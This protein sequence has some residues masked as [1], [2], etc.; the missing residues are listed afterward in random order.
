MINVLVL[1][2]LVRIRKQETYT[3]KNLQMKGCWCR[4]WKCVHSQITKEALTQYMHVRRLEP[5]IYTRWIIRSIKCI[6]LGLYIGLIVQCT[7]SEV[8]TWR[9]LH[10]VDFTYCGGYIRWSIHTMEF[11]R[12][13]VYIDWSVHGVYTG[14]SCKQHLSR[15]TINKKGAPR[16]WRS[17]RSI[18]KLLR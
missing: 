4:R 3:R 8:Y 9:S 5:L 7:H 14:W 10:M 18:M 12:G 1:I 6:H 16:F 15:S 2:R 17:V 13:G 11:T